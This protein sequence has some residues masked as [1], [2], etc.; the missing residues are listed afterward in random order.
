[1][2]MVQTCLSDRIAVLGILID[3]KI[4]DLDNGF[5]LADVHAADVATSA[6]IRVLRADI[7]KAVLAARGL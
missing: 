2:T 7:E 3:L 1:M 6:C 4:A 5:V